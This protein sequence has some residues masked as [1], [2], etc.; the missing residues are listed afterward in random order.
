MEYE[1]AIDCGPF[2]LTA[3]VGEGGMGVV[4]RGRHRRDDLPVAV[5]I[6]TSDLA[7]QE[8]YKQE[9]R[10]EVRAMARLHHP[11]VA[12]VVD[13]GSVDA[14]TARGGPDDLIEGAP[15]F[16]MEYVGG[17]DLVDVAADWEWPRVRR[18]LLVLL[19][20]LAHAHASDVIHRDL[21]PSNILVPEG[22]DDGELEVKLVD[23]GIAHVFGTDETGGGERAPDTWG[24]PEVM[25]PE[26]ILGKWRDQGPWTDLY[27]L[28][29]VAW[30][31]ITGRVP[32][33]GEDRSE[34]YLK[35]MS[36][37]KGPYRPKFEMPDGVERWLERM[38]AVDRR[39]RFRRAADAAYALVRVAQLPGLEA[40]EFE[41]EGRVTAEMAVDELQGD[42]TAGEK[43]D[44][45][46]GIAEPEPIEAGPVTETL[47]EEYLQASTPPVPD[48]WERAEP[49]HSPVPAQGTGLA[50]FDLRKIP[51]VDREPERN[52]LWRCLHIVRRTRQPAA[53]LLRG[54]A[55]SGKSRLVEWLAR[56]GH[57][58]GALVTLEATHS[59][60]GGPRD[61]LGPMFAR[62]FRCLDLPWSEG[63][64]RV[65]DIYESLG[66]DRAS[67]FHDAVGLTRMMGLDSD[68]ETMPPGFQNPNEKH[69]ALRRLLARIASRR[70]VLLW[71]DDVPW[72]W[73]SAR[74]AEFLL[75]ETYRQELPIYVVMTG[76]QS[77]IDGRPRVRRMLDNLR[78]HEC[79]WD[80][81]VGRLD[82]GAH[83]ML[84]ERLLQL[85]GDLVDEIV[86]RTEG[87]PLFAIQ[88]VG[89]WVERG[90]LR[91]GSEGFE[92]RE[93]AD[94]P[95]PDGPHELWSRR[96]RQVLAV[97][98]AAE[99]EQGRRAMQLA[100]ALGRQ[101]DAREWREVCRRA[102]VRA[103]PALVERLVEYGLAR[104][105]SGGWSFVHSM[106]TESLAR[107]A[108]R[109][110]EWARFHALCAEA[111]E[112]L[113]SESAAETHARRAKHL[114]EAGRHRE[115]LE[116][117]LRAAREARRLG[118]Y[119]EHRQ[120]VDRHAE[121]LD[122]LQVDAEDRRRARNWFERAQY[123]INTGE[124]ER[125]RELLERLGTAARRRQWRRELGDALRLRAQL[126]RDRGDLQACLDLADEADEYFTETDYFLGRARCQNTR[127]K[128]LGFLGERQEA[129]A[130]FRLAKSI[131]EALDR[132]IEVVRT[133]AWI[134][135]TYIYEGDYEQSRQRARRTL[136]R[137]REVGDKYTEGDAWNQLGECA[138]FER[139]WGQAR[140][141]Y[142]RAAREYDQIG[143]R[144]VYIARMN[145]AMVEVPA[146]RFERAG[147]EFAEL[148]GTLEEVG[149]EAR[150]SQVD[151]G[152]LAAAAGRGD[153]KEFDRRLDRIR[154]RHAAS[155]A[156]SKDSA[157]LAEHAAR[158]TV[159]RGEHRRARQVYELARELWAHLDDV[160]HAEA[161]ERVLEKLG[162]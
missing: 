134:N 121:V 141:Y 48:D 159:E 70:P 145:M 77:A 79:G 43:L 11:A 130:A 55:G 24:T 93:Q 81:P 112:E 42:G 106:L 21:K 86:E 111:I 59:P 68:T 124:S 28:G 64:E 123:C 29:C 144:G 96:I 149:W 57:E 110:G 26:Q 147:R 85:E 23:F 47:L 66:F 151:T 16:A 19:D 34:V 63:F 8:R 51:L 109:Q 54:P 22:D 67:S 101:V 105:E 154:E 60:K 13:Y 127:A 39:A 61:G 131:F 46:S 128:A 31:M 133:D 80:V 58:L 84:V 142:Q 1:A 107:Q 6:M 119:R 12:R 82:E 113:D 69:Y 139:E 95:I 99:R 20:A 49:D 53:V 18:A 118:A 116:P 92:L 88:L 117:L 15:W 89:D 41:Y 148:E 71:L 40:D 97:L 2:R 146:G 36:G 158:L 65:Q 62:H 153:W 102:G 98:P 137:A 32:F 103:H 104:R 52:R 156:V 150:L 56:R 33:A 100:A 30:W 138:R 37:R 45:A 7:R 140:R 50:L 3:P 161:I 14:E 5:K 38:L 120:W 9:F 75:E 155:E 4:Y 87:N 10:R 90:I 91:A 76:R 157:W 44:R 132:P 136:E 152:L 83:R 72:G 126:A 25:A 129:R 78:D 115:A 114:L 17:G 27:A 74:F 162:E 73:E 35:H 122:E 125:A 108:R 143:F 135:Y 160:E 94:R